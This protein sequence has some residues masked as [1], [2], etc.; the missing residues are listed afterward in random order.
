MKIKNL[1]ILTFVILFA[2]YFSLSA[3]KSFRMK[4]DIPPTAY[5]SHGI[6]ESHSHPTTP[7]TPSG[8]HIHQESSR[9][10]ELE[11]R[12]N[13]AMAKSAL[14]RNSHIDELVVEA[15]MKKKSIDFKYLFQNW[16]LDEAVTYKVMQVIR[17]RETRLTE[18]HF[19]SDLGGVEGI[20][21]SVT[22]VRQIHQSA[23]SEL[24]SL[25]GDDRAIALNNLEADQNKQDLADAL[26]L[27]G[28]R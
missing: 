6:H 19:R 11:Q 16:N 4:G 22:E 24:K 28:K 14:Q 13:Q 7:I 2:A 20:G 8:D 18:A 10:H 5:Q 12:L 21:E 3:Y 9:R 1:A 26:K 25:L 27:V 23:S 17:D 15:V